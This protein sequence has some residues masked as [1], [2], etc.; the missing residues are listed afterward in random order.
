MAEQ[1]NSP[2]WATYLRVSDEDK[3]SPERS[4]SMQR[5]RIQDQ[6]LTPSNM[7]VTREY[8]DM[9][10]GTSSNRADYQKM[11]A[12]AQVGK[13]SHL[14]LYR[15]DRFGRD[16]AEGLQ[17]ATRLIGMGI[18]LRVANMPS[19]TPET[20][21]GFFM[22]LIQMG[23]AQREV[24]VLKLR[25]ADGME[26]KLRAGGWAHKAPEGYLNKERQVS[27]NK[28]E[29]WVEQDPEHIQMIRQAWDLLLTDRYTMAEICEELH[30]RGFTRK[31]GRPWVWDDPKRNIRVRSKNRL[32]QIFHNPF[33]AGWVVSERFGIKINEIRGQWEAIIS[34]EE[35]KRGKEILHMH[36]LEKSRKKKRHYAL[37]NLLWVR[38]NGRTYKMYGSSP[39]PRKRNYAYYVTHAKPNG[40]QVR[41]ECDLVDDQITGWLAGIQIK[42]EH[43]PEIQA[44]YFAE[45]Q[46]AVSDN[47]V[48]KLSKLKRRISQ[49]QDEEARLGRLFMTEKISEET[50]ERLHAEWKEKS[51]HARINLQ[52]VEQDTT[53]HV[54]NLDLALVLMS[55]MFAI[56]QRFDEKMKHKLLSILVKRIIVNPQGEIVDHELHSPFEYLKNIA[57]GFSKIY[58]TNRSEQVMLGVLKRPKDGFFL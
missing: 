18:K 45:V 39:K 51:T 42:E 35:F 16:A 33:Y 8:C 50:Y 32:H 9:L 5:R 25:T 28:Y 27:S 10:T 1:N 36:D 2:G 21:D 30:A 47:R 40:S 34:D 37:R 57:Q 20:P 31:G 52:K 4:F 24:D 44:V 12:D 43:I 46:A 54:S 26:A 17:A 23:L 11:L 55:S 48:D 15:A 7:E 41:M 19:L 14:G 29:R 6:L 58:P 49:L 56:Y 53:I 38:S 22:F 3:Q 13:F